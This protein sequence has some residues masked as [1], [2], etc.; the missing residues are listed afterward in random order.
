MLDFI[1]AMES[2]SVRDAALRLREWFAMSA[3]PHHPRRHPP[4]ATDRSQSSPV[5]SKPTN[6][7]HSNS[8]VWITRIPIYRAAAS[9]QIL[10]G[11]SES[12]IT[13]GRAS[14]RGGL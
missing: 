9:P 6:R 12:A 14:W 8:A 7:C 10:P 5:R 3:E 2:C 13:V 4:D 1:A 11:T